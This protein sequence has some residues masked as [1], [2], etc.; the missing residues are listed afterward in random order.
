V[1]GGHG[2]S[3]RGGQRDLCRRGRWSGGEGNEMGSLS[4]GCVYFVGVEGSVKERV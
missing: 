3:V 1:S 4:G 2:V